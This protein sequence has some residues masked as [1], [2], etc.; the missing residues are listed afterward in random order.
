VVMQLS[1]QIRAWQAQND[2]SKSMT[3]SLSEV[4]C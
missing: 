1:Y 3:L 2:G 4:R